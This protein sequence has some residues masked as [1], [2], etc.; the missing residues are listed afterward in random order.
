MC[1]SDHTIELKIV[2]T[3]E[4]KL[5]LRL[6]VTINHKFLNNLHFSAINKRKF[7]PTTH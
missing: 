6:F 4:R 3:F 5:L 1:T 2:M 7:L